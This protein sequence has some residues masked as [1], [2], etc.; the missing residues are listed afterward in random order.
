MTH[1]HDLIAA[2]RPPVRSRP[3]TLWGVVLTALLLVGAM[4]SI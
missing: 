2:E 3:D 1:L 4:L